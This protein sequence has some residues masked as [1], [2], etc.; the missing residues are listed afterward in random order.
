MEKLM[1]PEQVAEFLQVEITTVT[2]W[3][4][5]RKIAGVKLGTMWR[6][7][8]EDVNKFI[9]ENYVNAGYD[10]CEDENGKAYKAKIIAAPS[11]DNP[12]GVRVIQRV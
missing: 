10:I 3:L 11:E 4:R 6:L 1:T 7:K 2:A 8:P 9:E 5:Q 12:L